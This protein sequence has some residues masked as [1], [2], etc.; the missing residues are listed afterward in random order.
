M[1]PAKTVT[2]TGNPMLAINLPTAI[3]LRIL[4]ILNRQR[5]ADQFAPSERADASWQ[6]LDPMSDDEIIALSVSQ[7]CACQ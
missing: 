3:D 4:K 1:A 5:V 6:H 2:T 7:L